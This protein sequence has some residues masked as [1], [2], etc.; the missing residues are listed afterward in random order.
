MGKKV[1]FWGRFDPGYSRNR[2]YISLFRELGWEVDFFFVK[3]FPKFGDVEACVR[4]LGRRPKPEYPKGC[5]APPEN[6][7][8]HPE[9]EYFQGDVCDADSVSRA[10]EGCRF[11]LHL[12]AYAKNWSKDKSIFYRFNVDAMENVFRAA[13]AQ[14]VE[15]IVSVL[16]YLPLNYILLLIGIHD[17]VSLIGITWVLISLKK[18]VYPLAGNHTDLEMEETEVQAV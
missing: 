9:F 14:N 18:Q 6:L 17:V 1:L 12:A 13:K 15:R 8:E 7:W 5:T 16:I 11:V 3:W 10:M 4:G 2:V